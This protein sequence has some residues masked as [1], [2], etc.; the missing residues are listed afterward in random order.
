MTR[1]IAVIGSGIGGLAA[2][3]RCRQVGWKVALFEKQRNYGMVAHGLKV[4]GGQVDVPLRV[5]GSQAWHSMTAALADALTPGIDSYR[6]SP[7]K[8]VQLNRQSISVQNERGE[9]GRF[10]QVIVATQANQLDFLTDGPFAA[11]RAVLEGIN[12]ARGELLVHQDERFMPARQRDWTALNF[13]MDEALRQ[14]MFTAWV[15]AV[16]PSLADKAPVFQTWEPLIEPNPD[17]VLARIPM[18]RA[19]VTTRTYG[20]LRQV[21]Q[22]Q[23]QP[24]RR[25]FYCGSWAAPGVPLLETAVQSAQAV[26][27]TI[28]N[29]D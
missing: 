15:N 28:L 14:S 22:W 16:E 6:G 20:I 9:G 21:Q 23:A 17:Q 11:E 8:R 1:S 2:A 13:Q 29:Q 27:A 4:D 26:V 25:L 10:D 3:Y 5:M 24:D 12:Y 7:V 19:L 18:Q